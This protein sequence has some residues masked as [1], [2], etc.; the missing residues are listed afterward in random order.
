M[1]IQDSKEYIRVLLNSS[2]TTI[3]GLFG[4]SKLGF[5]VRGVREAR[6]ESY[7]ACAFVHGESYP[8]ETSLTGV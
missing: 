6:R 8:P 2:Y 5:G 4:Y 7:G 1:I 3:T